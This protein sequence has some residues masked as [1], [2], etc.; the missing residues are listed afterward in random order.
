MALQQSGPFRSAARWWLTFVLGALILAGCTG[1]AGS[2]ARADPV[3]QADPFFPRM[4][5]KNGPEFTLAAMH[6]GTLTLEDGCLWLTTSETRHLLVWGPTHWAAWKNGR[7]A[8]LQN[9]KVVASVGDT[10]TVGGGELNV[11]DSRQVD[12]WVEAQI[13]Q[14]IPTECRTGLYWQVGGL[15]R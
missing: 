1:A 15:R 13:K 4:L 2:A 12:A 8:I 7:L 6:A 11:T 3:A 14:E 10:I 9:G 5:P